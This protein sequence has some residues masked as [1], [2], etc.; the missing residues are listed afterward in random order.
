LLFDGVFY[1][2]FEIE[3]FHWLHQLK[4]EDEEEEEEKGGGKGGGKEE[5]REKREKENGGDGKKDSGEGRGRVCVP[6]DT[7]QQREPPVDRVH[8]C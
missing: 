4:N 2:H 6:C 3:S 1:G 7:F 5:C 8:H